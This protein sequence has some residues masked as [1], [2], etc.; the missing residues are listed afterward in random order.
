MVVKR[1]AQTGEAITIPAFGTDLETAGLTIPAAD[2]VVASVTDVYKGTP[3]LAHFSAWYKTGGA[4]SFTHK[5]FR[6]GVELDATD[7]YLASNPGGEYF[8]VHFH[9]VDPAPP[10]GTHTY[11]VVVI[12]SVGGISD[13]ET[14][15]LTVQEV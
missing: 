3:V 8:P 1:V 11:D 9:W 14:R 7:E 15:R 5:F 13:I 4:D 2:T 10:P 6:D 12:S